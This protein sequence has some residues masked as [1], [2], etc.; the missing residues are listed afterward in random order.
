M[1]LLAAQAGAL[2]QEGEAIDLAQ[3]PAPIVFA[4]AA[5]S[6]LMMLAAAAD[7]AGTTDLRLANLLRLSHNLSV[8]M[9]LD[10][11]VR[12]ARLVVLRLL[13]GAAYW[14]YG[15]D[16]LSALAMQGRFRLALLPGD[17]NSDPI[18]MQRSTIAPE[19]WSR[20]HALFT[21]GGPENADL[22]LQSFRRLVDPSSGATRHLLPDGEKKPGAPVITAVPLPV[23]EG[24]DRPQAE[25]GEGTSHYLSP[26]PFPRFGMWHPA[27]GMVETLPASPHPN[28]PILFYRAALEGAGT[29][30]LEALIAALE[31]QQLNPV[32]IVVSTL[33]TR[34]GS[35][36]TRF[37]SVDSRVM[38]L[39][40]KIASLYS[41]AL[42]GD[43]ERS[44]GEVVLLHVSDLHLN[45]IGLAL[46][47]DLAADFE[48]DAVLDT[49]D[50]TSF[51]FEPETAFLELFDDFDVPYYLVAGNHDSA[52]VRATLARNEHVTLLDDE[53]VEIEGIKVLGVEDPTE[54]A[55]RRIPKDEINATYR[56]QF[57]STADLLE[58]QQPDLLMVHNPVQAR[59]AYGKV[60]TVG[61]GHIHTTRLEVV[62][63][64]VVAGVGSS[65]ATG[66]GDL[67][68]E[69][70]NPF[71]FQLLLYV[72]R[73]LVAIDQITLQGAD[74]DF[75][76]NRILLR[77]ELDD[78]ADDVSDDGAY[79]P[80]LE[81]MQELDPDS[82]TTTTVDGALL[83]PS[84][85]PTTT[86]TTTTE[87]QG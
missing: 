5:D 43:I 10:Q 72:D 37:G 9:W 84:P 28:V 20:L 45:T 69:G 86:S 76:L 51:G 2:Q 79:E 26:K 65:G 39:S 3:T 87:S 54:T 32:P 70:A 21:A 1:H 83:D 12:H 24:V 61:A 33:E 13:G 81:E 56:A 16:E 62:D 19:D 75:V 78:T 59:P 40:G 17:A 55:L 63:G 60:P 64:T 8:D 15:V 7:G 23:G 38:V 27:H 25:T 57:D 85:T 66:V 68:T 18:L 41:T 47:R 30:T 73:K 52:R 49:G 82:I 29:A 71:D 48:V 77:G 58:Q 67:L 22:L 14:Q 31:R 44:E 42:T 50:I 34:V 35:L 53:V 36:E 74:G 4:S 6:E 11:T 46:A 80:S